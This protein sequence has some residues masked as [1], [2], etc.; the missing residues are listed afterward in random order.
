MK[1]VFVFFLVSAVL[2]LLPASIAPESV[3][4]GTVAVDIRDGSAESL[5]YNAMKGEYS[6]EW[7]EK[8]TL[9]P[10]SFALSY[11]EEL[12][13]LLPMDDFLVSTMK[14]SEIKVLDQKGRSIITFIIRD[15]KIEAMRVDG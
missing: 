14:D 13:P 10:V 11:S 12:S 9:S 7:L 3:S 2:S 6:D 1:R 4:I 8:Y 5:I 15:G